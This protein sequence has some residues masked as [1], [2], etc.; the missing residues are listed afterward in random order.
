MSHTVSVSNEQINRSKAALNCEKFVIFLAVFLLLTYSGTYYVL[1]LMFKSASVN[2]R[3][4][5]P[6]S[7][8]L[9]LTQ[10]TD[11][12]SITRCLKK[13]I[14]GT[15]KNDMVGRITILTSALLEGRACKYKLSI[16]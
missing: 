2:W 8:N 7:Q 12:E 3:Y 5:F 11:A 9:S 15:D 4:L 14:E 13:P 6:P 10:K 16:P 1:S